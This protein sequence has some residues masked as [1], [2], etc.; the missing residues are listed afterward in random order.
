MPSLGTLS[1]NLTLNNSQFESGAKQSESTLGRLGSRAADVTKTVAKLGV[2]LGAAGAALVATLT[3]QGLAAVDAQAKLARSLDATADGVRAIQIAASD[4]GI[5]GLDRSL[6]ALNR[7]LG[8]VEMGGGPAADTL[9]RL[10]LSAQQLQEL[11]ADE[12]L[13][14]IADAIKETGMSSQESARHLQQLGFTQAEANDFFRQGG[15]AIRAARSEVD[16]Y[17]LSLSEVDA[18]QVEAAND[19]FSRIGRVIEV[20]RQRLAV[21]LAP[22]IEYVADLINDAAKESNGFREQIDSAITRG[23]RLGARLADIVVGV[24]RAFILAGQGAA[25]LGLMIVKSL[26]EASAYIMSTPVNAINDLIRTMN[27]VPGVAIEEMIQPRAVTDTR[28]KIAMMEQAVTEGKIAMQETLMAPMPSTGL[29]QRLE[30]IRAKSREA[31]EQVVAD[32]ERMAAPVEGEEEQAE[33]EDEKHREALERR[34]ER[35]QEHLMS[36]QELLQ[37]RHEQRL[38]ELRHFKE[39]EMLTEEE[40]AQMSEE[41]EAK[42]QDNLSKLLESGEKTRSNELARFAKANQAIRENAMVQ[43]TSAL[44]AGLQTMFG[45]HKQ[46]GK[47][48]ANLKKLEAIASAYAWGSSMGGPPGG[49][50]AASAAAYA[51][52][53]TASA[54][55]SASFSGG[56]TG[57][58]G[59]PGS[60]GGVSMTTPQGGG[61]QSGGTYVVRGFNENQFVRSDNMREMLEDM[62]KDGAG[63]GRL[64][65]E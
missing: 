54:V 18:A 60:D 59:A 40:F 62:W 47:A 63:S 6:V 52:T 46:F 25:T 51:Q 17:G 23:I 45:D 31:A 24:Q 43:E 3:K 64:I 21:Q 1:T 39:A 20:I 37:H 55:S 10:G 27:R 50:A 19:A 11:D 13:A 8:A 15:D 32:R 57:G 38:E 5:D 36:E 9:D 56:T 29:E 49:V 41:L 48:L 53:R 42:H 58:G 22:I 65:F 34:L 4:A 33:E 61:Q 12:R 26:H 14:A 44:R 28:E 35:L 2:G 7:R 16:E 30:E